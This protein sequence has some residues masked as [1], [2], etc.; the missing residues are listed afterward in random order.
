[1]DKKKTSNHQKEK[2][3]NEKQT[4]TN[5]PISIEIILGL[6]QWHLATSPSAFAIFQKNNIHS[7][8]TTCLTLSKYSSPRLISLFSKLHWKKKK[9]SDSHISRLSITYFTPPRSPTGI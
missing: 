5:K 6:L 3:R 4:K 9:K 8:I 1:M 2:E 7:I